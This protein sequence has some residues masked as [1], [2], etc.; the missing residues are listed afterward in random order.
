MK[1]KKSIVKAGLIGASLL[2][3]T[4]YAV[5]TGRDFTANLWMD[6][7]TAD[8]QVNIHYINFAGDNYETESI[9]YP[10][11][12]DFTL[13][14]ESEQSYKGGDVWFEFDLGNGNY[15][16]D[17]EISIKEVNVY[18]DTEHSYDSIEFQLYSL[19]G[20]D[21]E[22]IESGRLPYNGARTYRLEITNMPDQIVGTKICIQFVLN[23]EPIIE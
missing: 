12:S 13:N 14:Y 21:K 10:D 3:G 20:D 1:K 22:E 4:G 2:L 17:Y 5:V 15:A 18:D 23:V 7:P 8:V 16:V 11:F 9:D 6:A 19:S